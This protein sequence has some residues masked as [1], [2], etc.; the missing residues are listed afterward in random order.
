MTLVEG[1]LQQFPPISELLD[2]AWKSDVT[3]LLTPSVDEV[4]RKSNTMGPK[5]PYRF[6]A[7]ALAALREGLLL[8]VCC[9][10]N[11][12]YGNTLV[13]FL[14]NAY[15]IDAALLQDAYITG[16]HPKDRVI[17]G[18]VEDMPFKDRMFRRAFSLK[19]VGWYP[20]V[21]INPVSA[22][23]EMVRVT[24]DGGEV[25]ISIGQRSEN[26]QIILKAAQQVKNNPLGTR[27]SE[28]ADFTK[29]QIPRVC[30]ILS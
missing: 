7:S 24:E 21:T 28:V 27:I 15:G 14:P 30:I 20:N 2:P 11:F 17:G 12:G 4:I 8:D 22:I 29:E 25:V 16:D 9:G 10:L 5:S 6:H 26:S 1:V 18:F 13:D 19:G 23:A 3:K